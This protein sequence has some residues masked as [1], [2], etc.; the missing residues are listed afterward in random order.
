MILRVGAEK[1]PN[2]STIL[3]HS[4][5]KDMEDYEAEEREIMKAWEMS[6]QQMSQEADH[7]SM[8]STAQTS[9][10]GSSCSTQINQ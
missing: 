10:T 4:F 5:F 9:R 7:P 1:R 2:V 8:F 3:E 6:R